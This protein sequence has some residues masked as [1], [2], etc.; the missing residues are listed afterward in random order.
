MVR[1]QL[2]LA[3][4]ATVKRTENELAKLNAIEAQ[5]S[6]SQ[7]RLGQIRVEME[8]MEIALAA[9]RQEVQDE[10]AKL[11]A[12]N[13]NLKTQEE[14]LAAAAREAQAAW[15]QVPGDIGSDEEDLLVL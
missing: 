15:E 8:A 4:E 12:I 5:A 13:G 6:D 1:R 2:R 7:N 11:A 9:K 10:E 3:A 14:I